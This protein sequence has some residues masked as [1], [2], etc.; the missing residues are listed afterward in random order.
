L[1]LQIQI[2][3]LNDK[4]KYIGLSQ[5]LKIADLKIAKITWQSCKYFVMQHLNA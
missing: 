5:L 3:K 2:H 4:Y 1:T